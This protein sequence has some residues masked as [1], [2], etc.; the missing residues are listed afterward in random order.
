MFFS[1]KSVALG[2]LSFYMDH[3]VSVR[4]MRFAYGTNCVIEYDPQD[5]EHVKRRGKAYT[6]PSGRKVIPNNFKMILAKV[7]VSSVVITQGPQCDDV[8]LGDE[9]TRE[10]RGLAELL[11]GD[12]V[13]FGAEQ[14]LVDNSVLSWCAACASLDR[15]R[16]R[17]A[18]WSLPDPLKN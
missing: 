10:R 5:S 1:Q 15:C 7:R 17:Y 2:A 4:M 9:A 18:V 8:F 16:A 14:D 13:T 12:D 6:R 11:Q 3:F